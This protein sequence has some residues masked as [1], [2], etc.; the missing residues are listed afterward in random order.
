MPAAAAAVTTS[1]TA[2]KRR[3][4]GRM[5]R[6]S[7]EA[8]IRFILCAFAGPF[9][10]GGKRDQAS[11]GAAPRRLRAGRVLAARGGLV[12]TRRDTGA[13]QEGAQVTCDADLAEH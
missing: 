9:H 2:A 12:D 5:G 11:N 3:A 1:D 4:A 13:A 6:S 7:R 8:K 10:L